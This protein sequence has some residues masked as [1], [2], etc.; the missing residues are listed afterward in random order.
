M[1]PALL[2][3]LV[4]P[5]GLD[6]LLT[7]TELV[8]AADEVAFGL[9]VVLLL[10][11]EEPSGPAATGIVRSA[12][13]A[14]AAAVVVKRH[15]RDLAP[16]VAA[17]E[18]SG[19]ALLV[20]A[21]EVSW[22]HL[23]GLMSSMLVAVPGEMF[24]GVTPGDELFA[25]ANAV[26][27]AVG[28]SV[29]IE[30]L[31]HHVLAYSTVPGQRIDELRRRGILDRQV[32]AGPDDPD[33]YR[34]VLASSGVVRIPGSGDELPRMAT[35]IR[36]GSMAIGTL[37][38]I[39]GVQPPDAAAERSVAD[40]ARLAALALLRRQSSDDLERLQRAELLRGLLDGRLT[41]ATAWLRLGLPATDRSV[42]LGVAASWTEQSAAL[43][44]EIDRHARQACLAVLPRAVVTITDRAV[45]VLVTGKE[46]DR[47]ARRFADHFLALVDSTGMHEVRIAT[48][49]VADSPAD[50]LSRRAEVDQVL[51]MATR[52]GGTPR[53]VRL[54]DVRSSILLAHLSELL[55]AHP[56][57]AHPGI[58]RLLELDQE[59]RTEMAATVL[60]W[61]EENGDYRAAAEVL[62]VHPNTVRY[63][64][65]RV[66]KLTGVH[67]DEPDDRLVAWLQLLGALSPTRAPRD[68]V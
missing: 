2:D 66:R 25:V 24:L 51:A 59:K 62:S 56:E 18:T 67:L 9:G 27:A 65:R 34:S 15:G 68:R 30:D 13:A 39:E 50:L 63:R 17:A 26:A 46:P 10:V 64:L 8:D 20:A 54:A 1:G 22:R 58:A 55:A 6:I 44:A 41:P 33:Q 29:A 11:T 49:A 52:P 21:D 23:D 45:Y 19:V 37:W 61:I 53:I 42:L 7:R 60:A 38:A 57:L 47:S 36:A 40:G 48:A 4:A 32:P 31:A 43:L 5:R 16:L 12:G 28:G 14:G 3:L 35:A